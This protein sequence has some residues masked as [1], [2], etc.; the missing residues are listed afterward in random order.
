MKAGRKV[1]RKSRPLTG[2]AAAVYATR[3]K[4]GW[5]QADFAAK[6]GCNPIVIGQ[7]ERGLWPGFV[8]LLKVGTF[9][10]GKERAAIIEAL[11][12][13]APAAVEMIGSLGA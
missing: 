10:E 1:N 7:M 5:S 6:V 13:M 4:R 9:A 12:K 8:T 2:I 11:R 3:V